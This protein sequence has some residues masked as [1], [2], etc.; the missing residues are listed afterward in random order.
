MSR[1]VK[2]KNPILMGKQAK[3]TNLIAIILF[4][5]V[6][7]CSNGNNN[8]VIKSITDFEWLTGKWINNKDTTALFFENWSKND[9]GNYMG[10]SYILSQKDTVFFESIQITN[11]DSGA[12]Y[13]V[14]V[15]NQNVNEVVN[16]KL[17]SKV[18]HTFIF[19]N[20]NHDFPQRIIYQYNAPD[21]LLAWIEGVV[22]GKA[23]KE[24]F[25]M[26]RNN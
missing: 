14:T 10:I 9:E 17:V 3:K 19:E 7:A 15:R 13:S 24:S 4:V 21:T 22:K 1:N 8:K 25:L 18:N 6:S 23:R 16:F 11:A 5:V 12:Y 20:K 26:W 2:R